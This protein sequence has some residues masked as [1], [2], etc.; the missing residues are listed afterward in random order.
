MLMSILAFIIQFESFTH[1]AYFD[2][3][4]YTYGYGTKAKS[5]ICITETQAAEEALEVIEKHYN[6]VKKLPRLN[7]AQTAALTSF[8]YNVGDGAF[9][10]SKLYKLVEK[11]QFCRAEKEFG[12]W[13][14]QSGRKL[15]GLVKRRNAE[16]ALFSHGLAC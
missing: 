14:Y 4:Q 10:T 9:R 2:R 13:V 3:A 12:K 6:I 8:S 5:N 16:K 1:T 15:S 11:G 7:E